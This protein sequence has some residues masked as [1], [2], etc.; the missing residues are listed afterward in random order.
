[1]TKHSRQHR[2][3]VS[4]HERAH[5]NSF[6]NNKWGT[7][8]VRE[9]KDARGEWD[10]CSICLSQAVDATICP[11]GNVYC[12]ECIYAFLL[13]QKRQQKEQLEVFEKQEAKGGSNDDAAAQELAVLAQFEK[14]EES[15]RIPSAGGGF[16]Y[17]GKKRKKHEAPTEEDLGPAEGYKV[18]KTDNGKVFLVD[19]DVVKTTGK[20]TENLSVAEREKRGKVLPCFWIPS[21]TPDSGVVKVAKPEEGLRD[22]FG[23]KLKLKHLMKINYTLTPEAIKNPKLQKERF[24]CP[25]SKKTFTSG[26]QIYYVKAN[27]GV[28]TSE[29]I[30]MILTDGN[31][32]GKK[33]RK[34]DVIQF[35]N[36]G[37]G[38]AAGGARMV[39]S[40]N[41]PAFTYA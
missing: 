10:S 37:T 35:R 31:V 16:A 38:Y 8:K 1:M 9:G 30:K 7:L 32:D 13:S 20:S 19:E 25:I 41:N 23:N 21:L 17:Q 11:Q 3:V 29:A 36:T 4:A 40:T 28:Y 5:V 12:K 24:M 2:D 27:E 39:T 34:K 6:Y 26:C 14:L 22:P 18:Y 33:V 15:T